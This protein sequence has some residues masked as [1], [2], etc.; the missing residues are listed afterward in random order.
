MGT[1]IY[2]I[3]INPIGYKIKEGDMGIFISK[4]AQD[5][6][7]Y[8]LVDE[9]GV[10]DATIKD[11]ELK[12]MFNKLSLTEKVT[13]SKGEL[14]VD[15]YM[16]WKNDMRGK[17]WKHIL[18]IG[19]IEHYGNLLDYMSNHTNQYI[20]YVSDQ[21]PDERWLKIKR[22]YSYAVYFECDLRNIEELARTAINFAAHTIL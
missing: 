13:K 6:E 19:K 11:Q 14:E 5:A 15:H 8:H 2:D 18:V 17:L 3:L 7:K 21:P 4:D 12:N 1:N 16:L 20:C 10:Y 9:D 22:K